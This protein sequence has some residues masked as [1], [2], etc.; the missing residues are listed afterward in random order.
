MRYVIVDLDGASRAYFGTRGEVL[1]ELRHLEDETPGI[2][3]ELYVAV[4]GDDGGPRKAPELADELLTNPVLDWSDVLP[5]APPADV[6]IG[7]KI[8]HGTLAKT[9]RTSRPE[10]R[11]SAGVST[12][13]GG[14]PA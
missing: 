2:A 1:N 12:P 11:L 4:Y 14:V 7:S 6:L 8:A 10:I 9:S 13:P 3:T 5:P